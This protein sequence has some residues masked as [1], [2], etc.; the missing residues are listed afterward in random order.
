VSGLTVGDFG[1]CVELLTIADIRHFGIVP[2]QMLGTLR[3]PDERIE[4]D[5][6]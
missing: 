3:Q 6:S 4:G 2:T 5:C 1:G